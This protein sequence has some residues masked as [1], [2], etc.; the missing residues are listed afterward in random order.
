MDKMKETVDQK[1]RLRKKKEVEKYIDLL[2]GKNI[3]Y[4]E[5]VMKLNAGRYTLYDNLVLTLFDPEDGPF[6]NITVNLEDLPADEFAVD[7]NNFPE[8]IGILIKN[9]V[10]E[11]SGKVIRSGYCIYPVY[12]LTLDNERRFHNE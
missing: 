5:K 1:A 8:A 9:R 11:F 4:G 2:H 7:Q 10:A 3:I 12:K 6:A